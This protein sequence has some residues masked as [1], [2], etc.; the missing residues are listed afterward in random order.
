MNT[1]AAS[2]LQP[3]QGHVVRT[4]F[5][6]RVA[7]VTCPEGVGPGALLQVTTPSGQVSSGL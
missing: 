1:S 6:S 3:A 4:T 2:W 5:V 7:Q